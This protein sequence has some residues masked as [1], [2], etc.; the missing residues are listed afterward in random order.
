MKT[1]AMVEQLLGILRRETELYQA[2]SLVMNKEKDAA[3]QVKLIGLNEAEMEKDNILA[4]LALL[5]EQR[6]QLVVCLADTLGYPAQDM[7]LTMISQLAGEPLAGR[8]RQA[9]SDLSVLLESLQVANQHNKQ[10]FEHSRELLT[11]SLNLLSEL[12][13]PNPIYYRTGTVRNTSA[14]GKCVCDEI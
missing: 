14:A 2:M 13:A 9:R 11:G 12:K 10:I 4:A 5:E 6:H 1:E 7:N 3:I 8:L